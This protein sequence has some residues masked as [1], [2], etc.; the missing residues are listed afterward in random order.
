MSDW[1]WDYHKENYLLNLER[2]LLFVVTKYDNTDKWY[3]FVNDLIGDG[4]F[5]STELFDSPDEAKER[6]QNFLLE[7]IGNVQFKMIKELY[8]N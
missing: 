8:G 4:G 1:N 3:W 5:A 7:V 6:V 2:K